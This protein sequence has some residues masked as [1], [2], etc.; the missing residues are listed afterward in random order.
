MILNG[1]CDDIPESY[2]LFGQGTI[3]E[4]FEKSQRISKGEMSYEYFPL[5]IG[6]PD[7]LLFEGN[8]GV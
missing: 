2:F 3:D 1:E 8:V 5:R 4:V 7:G 6:T